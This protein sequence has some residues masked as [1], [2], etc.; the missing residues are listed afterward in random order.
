L[1]DGSEHLSAS[2][3][4]FDIS[5][6]VPRLWAV[7]VFMLATPF[8]PVIHRVIAKIATGRSPADNF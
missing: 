8:G 3:R 2:I 7:R 6:P 1:A 5:D 4:S